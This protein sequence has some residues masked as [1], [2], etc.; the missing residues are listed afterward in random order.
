MNKLKLPLNLI[1]H[2]VIS[3]ADLIRRRKD[4]KEDKKE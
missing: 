1:L 4:K 3:I 2:A